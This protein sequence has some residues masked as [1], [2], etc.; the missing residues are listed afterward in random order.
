MNPI[1]S[2][3][4]KI[5]AILS[6]LAELERQGHNDR[7]TPC[8]N[9]ALLHWRLQIRGDEGLDY[10]WTITSREFGKQAILSDLL[11]FK[12]YFLDTLQIPYDKEK[13]IDDFEALSAYL[14]HVDHKYFMFRDFQSRN[15]MLKGRR[16]PFYRFPGRDERRPA[17]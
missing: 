14:T 3:S 6:L 9:K 15:I 10:S 11:Y 7:Y 2:I 17:I 1:P 13:L 4:R 16:G 5:S 12:Y 8:S